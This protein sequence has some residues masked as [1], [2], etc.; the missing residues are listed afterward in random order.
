MFTYMCRCALLFMNNDIYIDIDIYRYEGEVCDACQTKREENSREE[1]HPTFHA[2][3]PPTNGK[4]K[5]IN[6]LP[7]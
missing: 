3:A 4:N 5:T 2:P 1:N 7:Q 6:V